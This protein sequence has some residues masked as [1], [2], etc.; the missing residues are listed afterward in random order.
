[1]QIGENMNGDK[2][3]EGLNI[4]EHI[5][6][7]MDGNGRWAQEKGKKRTAG[8]REG[9][10]TLRDVCEASHKYGV[11]Y[12]TVYAFSTENWKRSEQEVSFLMN[13]L[14]QFL[15]DSIKES[16]KNNMRVR[17]IG[18]ISP[19]PDDIKKSIKKMESASKDNTGLNLQVAL[20]YGSRDEMTRGI[21]EIAAAVKEGSI[22]VADIDEE[23]VTKHLDTAGIPDP[24]LLIRPGKEQRLSNYLLWQ[25]A[26]A[27]FYFCDCYW[28]DFDNEELIR[29]IETY[30]K[31][32][33][34][35][36]GVINED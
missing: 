21:K 31:V 15:K 27:E 29:A 24:D 1:M 2:R 4:P 16:K 33:R 25:L 14:K 5:A 9:A 7:I 3:L 28:P 17:V 34:R 8:H 26:Y 22:A 23:M 36:G 20:N 12:V 6:F 35:F 30:N 18:D 10:N 19:F 32:E 13:L 11:K